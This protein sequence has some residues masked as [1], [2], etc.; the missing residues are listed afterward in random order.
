M[1][2]PSLANA[3]VPIEAILLMP[4]VLGLCGW[5]GRTDHQAPNPALRQRATALIDVLVEVVGAPI[6]PEL[7]VALD[8]D[9]PRAFAAISHLQQ[10]IDAACDQLIE[11]GRQQ[12]QQ[13]AW[14]PLW[15]ESRVALRLAGATASARRQAQ[16]ALLSSTAARGLGDNASAAAALQTAIA[17]AAE[18]G[19]RRM[20]AIAN[21]NL[22]NTLRDIG[23][24]DDAL[25]YYEEALG[26]ENDARGRAQVLSSQA[27][28]FALLGE[29]RK[30][31]TAH[32]QRA[33]ELE[34]TQTPPAELAI[35]LGLVAADEINLGSAREALALLDRVGALLAD[36]DH[37][38]LAVTALR[39]A[40]AL[41]ALDAK[42]AAA[43]AFEMAWTHAT[44]RANAQF[45]P[46]QDAH[47]AQGLAN[48]CLTRLG[49]D[50][51]I[52]LLLGGVAAK[53]HDKWADAQ[54]RLSAA[55]GVA[56]EA[57]DVALCLRIEVNMA[58]VA[59]DAGQVGQA[60]QLL[61]RVR[62]EAGQRGLSLQEALATGA[63]GAIAARTGQSFDPVGP[64]GLYARAQALT[65]LHARLL[66]TS[67]LSI[68]E[69]Q[70][71]LAALDTGALDN[72]LALLAQSYFASEFAAN[73]FKRAAAALPSQPP[74]FE[75]ANR[76]SGLLDALDRLGRDAE[77]ANAAAQ[78][79]QMIVGDQLHGRGRLVVHRAL[80]CHL[81]SRDPLAAIDHLRRACTAARALR[82]ELP[83][84]PKRSEVN[85]DFVHLHRT[86]AHLLQQQGL[87][88]EAFEAVQHDKSRLLLDTLAL[89]NGADDTPAPLERVQSLLGPVDL[90]VDLVLY[91]DGITA[92]LVRREGLRSVRIEGATRA[93]TN[94]E[95]GDIAEREHALL[96][97]CST[98]RLLAELVQRIEADPLID[99]QA[100]LIL[101]P[102][103]AT[104]N[105]PLHV[106]PLRGR[107]WCSTRLISM[108][109][110]AGALA[111]L[112]RSSTSTRCLVAGDS[113]LNLP[114]AG[115]EC[116]EVAALLRTAPMVGLDCGHT[117]VS[118]ALRG[119]DL[120]IVHLAVHGRGDPANG[121]RASLLLGDDSGGVA[122]VS[123]DELAT[124]DWRCTFMALS[125]CSTGAAGPRAGHELVSVARAALAAGATSVLACLWPV[126]DETARIFMSAFYKTLAIE[127]AKGAVDLRLLLARAQEAVATADASKLATSQRRDGRPRSVS[128]AH[129]PEP[130][131]E[132]DRIA[133]WAP[134]VLLGS[135]ALAT[136][137]ANPG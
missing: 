39:R 34:S 8:A 63:L 43:A 131:A 100:R 103:D 132:P 95:P 136:A 49:V 18:A 35:A 69:R 20:L 80:G 24:I 13:N 38:G 40:E 111:L 75:L 66:E 99:P 122:W 126:G 54:Q 79:D 62:R 47:Y 94:F 137:A 17:A 85:R 117:Q 31:L 86:L 83:A 45:L 59:A 36:E 52:A 81:A 9:D 61:M 7:V 50:Q 134:F 82:Q 3:V 41:R 2:H 106:V 124:L 70:W 84:G 90:L 93:L 23:R 55:H 32:R 130:H 78:L 113:A 48:A 121:G 27:V 10:Q 73:A 15:R 28:A 71:D 107:P 21:G 115:A 118:D 77:A 42:E 5:H 25:P 109:P 33:A 56:Q 112:H 108:L 67:S 114:E 116:I 89:R 133:L 60:A 12:S 129:L 6:P 91:N 30:A 87:D 97:L 26:W 88:R 123:F 105:L 98:D 125:G 58:A 16:A 74:S 101:V 65:A 110:C 53:G 64:M 104:H 102:D 14:Q 19:D 22:A 44:A 37:Q 76:R 120:D 119:R 92:Y 68:K 46:P 128:P 135:P 11:R 72:Q 4:A 96:A 57:N 127:R 29:G 1:A 51:A